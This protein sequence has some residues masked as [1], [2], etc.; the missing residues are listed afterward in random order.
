MKL[1]RAKYTRGGTIEAREGPVK[2]GWRWRGGG[3]GG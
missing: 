2:E 1:A 3:E